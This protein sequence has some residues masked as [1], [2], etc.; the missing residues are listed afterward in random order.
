MRKTK[1]FLKINLTSN[2]LK[3]HYWPLLL[4][5]F[6]EVIFFGELNSFQ[7]FISLIE[8]I[9]LTFVAL[10]NI[11]IAII[12]FVCFSLLSYGAWSYIVID[13]LPA[14][15]WG[16]RFLGISVNLIFSIYLLF[17]LVLKDQNRNTKYFPK[18]LYFLLL[19]YG[20]SIFTGL[21]YC[22]FNVN[23]FDNYFKDL[24]IFFPI[25]IY[26]FLIFS[27]G[28]NE[29]TKIFSYCVSTTIFGM[30]FSLLFGIFFE[31][32]SGLNFILLNSF[33]YVIMFIL[34]FCRDKFSG[35]HYYILVLIAVLLLASGKFF[36]GGKFIILALMSFFWYF[37]VYKRNFLLV[38][39]T[40]SIISLF[41]FFW[42]EITDYLL[43][44]FSD[45]LL[46]QNKL[47]QVIS[48]VEILDLDLLSAAPTSIGNIIAE[49]RTIF[50]YY[51]DSPIIA[52]TGL[53][54]GGGVPDVYG[55]LT[56]MANP[57][58]GY[59]EIDAVRNNFFRMHLPVFEF[60]L[61]LGIFGGAYYLYL[62]AKSFQKQNIFSLYFFLIFFTVFT[63]NKEM[64]MLG[65]F[66]LHLSS[67][68][69]S[70]IKST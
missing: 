1:N 41:S 66:F 7:V 69:D 29:T 11:R 45:N 4:F 62:S 34:P 22:F 14:N 64:I 42:I 52:I 49:L 9:I 32:G 46:V 18:E 35:Y 15:F 31:Y 67:I 63:N 17:L 26:P 5:S 2:S 36:V 27:L 33:G 54:F 61:K 51:K 47:S 68:D 44:F 16:I 6:F 25:L 37:L 56:P 40:I 10:F 58:M 39:L 8:Y 60:F 19:F 50:Q 28:K 65:L 3:F 53:G 55:F 21:I 43:Y 20:V 59:S 30:L 70:T 12:Y 23:Y 57:G 24:M 13:S 48:I 38:G